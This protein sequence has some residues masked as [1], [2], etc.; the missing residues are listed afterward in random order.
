M[1]VKKIEETTNN[2]IYNRVYSLKKCPY[3][4]PLKHVILPYIKRVSLTYSV[5]IHIISTPGHTVSIIFYQLL[6]KHSF[7][8]MLSLHNLLRCSL[9]MFDGINSA[10]QENVYQWSRIFEKCVPGIQSVL[11]CLSLHILYQ[12]SGYHFFFIKICFTN[13]SVECN[14]IE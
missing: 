7:Q 2:K 14:S 1:F 8:Y 12:S 10:I 3:Y 9:L 11:F 5:P 6:Q 13:H 4:L